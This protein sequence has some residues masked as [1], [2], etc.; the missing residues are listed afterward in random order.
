MGRAR[1]VFTATRCKTTAH[2][3]RTFTPRYLDKRVLDSTYGYGA[4]WSRWLRSISSLRSRSSED[5]IVTPWTFE[6]CRSTISP[7]IPSGWLRRTSST[8]RR[9]TSMNAMAYT[10][11]LVG[12]NGTNSFG[13]ESPMLSWRFELPPSQVHDQVCS[14]ASDGRPS[15][16]R[17]TPP[18]GLR[19]E[20]RFDKLVTRRPQPKAGD[21]S[22]PRA[23]IRRSSSFGSG[24]DE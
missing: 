14:G 19:L 6:R 7:S 1:D 13:Q 17:L 9:A 10:F 18:R 4:F 21:S 23:T 16:S 3:S 8:E 11:R 15:S 12:E 2:S 24:I 20:D 5:P 22:T